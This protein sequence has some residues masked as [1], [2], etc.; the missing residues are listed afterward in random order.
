MEIRDL[1]G[2]M[3]V[4]VGE[5]VENETNYEMSQKL[6]QSR[7]GGGMERPALLTAKSSNSELV[8]CIIA[9]IPKPQTSQPCLP[10]S[11]LIW[12]CLLRPTCS[13][14]TWEEVFPLHNFSGGIVKSL[15]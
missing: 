2:H 5:G 3:N 4:R 15:G 12:Q 11:D 8:W 6:N 9:V 1:K 13:C 10:R 7:G 14:I